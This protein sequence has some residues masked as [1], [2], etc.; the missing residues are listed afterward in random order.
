MTPRE[1]SLPPRE[2]RGELERQMQR[3]I[4]ADFSSRMRT[5][6]DGRA[7]ASAEILKRLE[8]A[9]PEPS[10]I[11]PTSRL[12]KPIS[13]PAYAVRDGLMSDPVNW[14]YAPPFDFAPTNE[15]CSGDPNQCEVLA[16][17]AQNELNLALHIVD[18]GADLW[19]FAG[20]GAWFTP[21]SGTPAVVSFNALTQWSYDYRLTAGAIGQT[22]HSH[23]DLGVRVFSWDAQW[24]DA[25]S[26]TDFTPLWAY[27]VDAFDWEH[28]DSADGETN[29]SVRVPFDPS[30]HY[31]FCAYIFAACDADG[32]PSSMATVDFIAHSPF[33]VTEEWTTG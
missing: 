25:Q 33:L 9:I 26:F 32:Y 27:G 24:G 22:A 11:A 13:R 16:D 3:S 7:A 30:R 10:R 4:E 23:G 19:G 12:R 8:M 21:H 31:A 15:Y 1:Q 28:E 14:V 17:S 5:M 18:N 6:R 29:S 2:L 20:L